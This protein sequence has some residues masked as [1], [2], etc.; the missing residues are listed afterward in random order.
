MWC[1][2]SHDITTSTSLLLV[3]GPGSLAFLQ[4]LELPDH[5]NSSKIAERQC[6]KPEA[7]VDT[8]SSNQRR[9][10]RLD[11]E[12]QAHSCCL[13]ASQQRAV[14]DL[15]SWGVTEIRDAPIQRNNISDRFKSAEKA[16]KDVPIDVIFDLSVERRK[17]A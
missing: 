17:L 16:A 2:T 14:P 13:D 4:L 10:D 7:A 15:V 12:S 11:S 1:Y 8:R 3:E 6:D 5:L 9:R